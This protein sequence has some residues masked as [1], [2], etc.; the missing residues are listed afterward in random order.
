MW[1]YPAPFPSGGGPTTTT[2][3]GR[4][5]VITLEVELMVELLELAF[6]EVP[7][8]NAMDAASVRRMRLKHNSAMIN[9]QKL[10]PRQ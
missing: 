4:A 3:D 1:K 9:S 6:E 5:V 2:G 10:E 8:P 7:C